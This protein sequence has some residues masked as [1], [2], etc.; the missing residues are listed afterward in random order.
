M[1][2]F[3]TLLQ[4]KLQSNGVGAESKPKREAN[5]AW[6]SA[7]HREGLAFGKKE[8][9]I[10]FHSTAKGEELYIQYPGKESARAGDSLRPWDFRPELLLISRGTYYET[11]SFS[12][13]WGIF[14]DELTSSKGYEPA[15]LRILAILFYRMAYILDHQ[16][17]DKFT[18]KT[19]TITYLNGK[20]S[21][22][23]EHDE[24][25]SG[26][27]F[28][29]TLSD[30]IKKALAEH[31]PT[32]GGIS[33]EAFLYYNDL[34]AWNE[35][36]KYYYRNMYVQGNNTWIDKIGRPNNLLTHISVLGGVLGDIKFQDI[37]GGLTNNGVAPMT[38]K[39]LRLI[40]SDYLVP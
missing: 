24:T 8:K 25:F 36:C 13:I 9:Q 26:P 22:Q 38:I 12:N 29:Y 23:E 18:T 11:R 39:N 1:D 20:I 40:F 30:D 7:L 16:S 35:D 10:L 2:I 31:I 19:R 33:S 17:V 37:M 6:I 28:K 15:F 32:I 34:L 4:T 14:I 27:F 3:K 21:E 5:I